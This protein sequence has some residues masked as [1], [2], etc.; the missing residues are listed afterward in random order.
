MNTNNSEISTAA[1]TLGR[2]GGKSRSERK[3]AA[4]RENGKLGGRPRKLNDVE[5][6]AAREEYLR[7]NGELMPKG[8][9]QKLLRE[10][11]KAACRRQ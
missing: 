8:A 7:Q 10:Y 3:A 1:A 2:L 9:S 5:E 6:D 11:F 4:V